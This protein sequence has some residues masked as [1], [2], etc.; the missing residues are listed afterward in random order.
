MKY[1]RF[2]HFLCI[3]FFILSI[4]YFLQ[5][6]ATTPFSLMLD[7]AG[8]AQHTGRILDDNFERGITLQFTESLKKILEQRIPSLRIVL[9]RFPGETLLPLQNANFSNRLDAD[10]YISFHFYKEEQVKPSI[11]I[12]TFSYGN[13]FVSPSDNDLS[14]YAY[15]TIHRT[16]TAS[17]NTLA[18]SL[19]QMLKN[20]VYKNKFEVQGVFAIPHTELIGIKA[21]A[22]SIEIGLKNKE[23]WTTYLEALA[24][25]LETI[26]NTINK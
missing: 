19:K 10:L 12:Y 3:S 5:T 7:P 1:Q 9:T 17:T 14:F 20:P 2:T 21:P 15:N 22:L 25:S 24:T 4:A 23:S 26:I 11:F 6:S 16:H 8:D 18:N 13:E